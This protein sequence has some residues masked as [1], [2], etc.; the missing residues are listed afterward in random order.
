MSA[1]DELS[2]SEK[3][4]LREIAINEGECVY[5][6]VCY[7]ITGGICYNGCVRFKA[8]HSKNNADDR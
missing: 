3:K 5:L 8:Y 4:M 7:P 2:E 6:R 1:H